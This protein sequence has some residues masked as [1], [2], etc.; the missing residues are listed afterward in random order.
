MPLHLSLFILLCGYVVREFGHSLENTTIGLQLSTNN[1]HDPHYF[2]NRAYQIVAISN[3]IDNQSEGQIAVSSA[4]F[5]ARN[6]A[7]QL[8]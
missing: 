4:S 5:P 6:E 3:G 7:S 8:S 2:Q 1:L